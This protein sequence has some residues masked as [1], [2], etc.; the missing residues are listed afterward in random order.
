MNY[1]NT[2]IME[3]GKHKDHTLKFIYENDENYLRWLLSEFEIKRGR[4]ALNLTIAI[5]KTL[6]PDYVFISPPKKTIILIDT[7]DETCPW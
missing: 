7:G 3:F 1:D 4:F 6:N 5:N 2:Y